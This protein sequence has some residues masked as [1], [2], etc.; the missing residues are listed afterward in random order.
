[1][2]D[3]C[4]LGTYKEGSKTNEFLTGK[5]LEVKKKSGAQRR[6]KGN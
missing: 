1:M 5:R 2:E 4:G 3:E 6:L